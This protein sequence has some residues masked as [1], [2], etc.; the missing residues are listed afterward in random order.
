MPK[1][2]RFDNEPKASTPNPAA[3]ARGAKGTSR[4]I[5]KARTPGYVPPGFT[6]RTRIDDIMFTADAS[7]DA[8]ASAGSDPDV[9]SVARAERLDLT[10]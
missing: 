2:L 4:V 1:R 5:V 10:D 8:V 3:A 9:E 6:V 7:A